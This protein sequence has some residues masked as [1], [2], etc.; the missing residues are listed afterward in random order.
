MSP[1]SHILLYD[2]AIRPNESRRNPKSQYLNSLR[3]VGPYGPEAKQ[4]QNPKDRNSKQQR[5][6]SF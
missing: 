6:N 5:E 2:V 4:I 3:G 1:S